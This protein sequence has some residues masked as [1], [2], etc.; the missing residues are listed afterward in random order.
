MLSSELP[1]ILAIETSTELGSIAL[2]QAGVCHL[3]YCPSGVANS[4][5][6]LPL[7]ARLLDEQGIGFADL[8][9]I[10]FGAGPGAFTGLRVACAVAQGLAFARK[11]ALLPVNTLAALAL[12]SQAERVL[13]ALDARMGEVYFGCFE[14]RLG[15]AFIAQASAVP[16]VAMH[17]LS[18]VGVYAPDQVPLPPSGE[19]L[20]CGNALAAYPSLVQRLSPYVRDFLPDLMPNAEAVLRLA[21]PCFARGESVA[22][23]EAVPIYVR[24]KVAQTTAERL[25]RGGK[26]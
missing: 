12:A 7:I 13:V 25:A 10:A 15:D 4:L 19:W 6:L 9:G 22:A 20:A 26:A 14:R 21:L 8:Q 18:A 5:T 11:L 1:P 3:R 23:A 24:D 2:W 17:A 16:A